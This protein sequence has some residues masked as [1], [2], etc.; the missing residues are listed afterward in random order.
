MAGAALSRSGHDALF[1]VS[2]ELSEIIEDVARL[3]TRLIIQTAAEAEVDAFVGPGLAT[4]ALLA[5]RTRERTTDTA[6]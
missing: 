6:T 1:H 4:S 5:V 2:P 3:G